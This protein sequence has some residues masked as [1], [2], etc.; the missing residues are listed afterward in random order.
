MSEPLAAPGRTKSTRAQAATS[1]LTRRML[2][3]PGE[4]KS[5]VSDLPLAFGGALVVVS[6]GVPASWLTGLNSTRPKAR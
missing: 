3:S 2:G 5:S 6:P 4:M 1:K